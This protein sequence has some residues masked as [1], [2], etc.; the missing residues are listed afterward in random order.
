MIRAIVVALAPILATS[1]LAQSSDTFMLSSE[2]GSVI[3]AEEFCGLTY[4]QNAIAA[5]IENKVPAD[6]MGFAG[7]LNM[8]VIG[9][10]AMQEDMTPSLKTAHC[11]QMGRVARSYGFTD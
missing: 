9:H 8:Q 1:A 3:A 6:D 10:G 4:D 2:L 5:F 7:M 11:A